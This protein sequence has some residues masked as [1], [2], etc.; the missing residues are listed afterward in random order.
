[1]ESAVLEPRSRTDATLETS[2]ADFPNIGYQ[3]EGRNRSTW[4]TP[5][6]DP[7][8]EE[9]V[10]SHFRLYPSNPSRALPTSMDATIESSDALLLQFVYSRPHSVRT[11]LF[12]H[13]ASVYGISIQH[14]ALRHAMIADAASRIS[15]LQFEGRRHHHTM[16]ALVLIKARLSNPEELDYADAF[17]TMFLGRMAEQ[18]GTSSESELIVHARGC[19]SILAYLDGRPNPSTVSSLSMFQHLILNEIICFSPEGFATSNYKP[20]T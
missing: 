1:V 2:S 13:F 19:L 11:C 6:R 14:H 20:S 5:S 16:Q 3:A 4:S 8:E 18:D 9:D 12:R 7:G 10:H 17:T 15:S